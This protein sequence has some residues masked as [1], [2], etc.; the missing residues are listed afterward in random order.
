MVRCWNR[1]VDGLV[2]HVIVPVSLV[3][4]RQTYGAP[5]LLPEG[6]RNVVEVGFGKLAG[7]QWS[8]VEVSEKFLGA[9]QVTGAGPVPVD[10]AVR[11]VGQ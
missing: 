6:V 8:D 9:N 11:D 3:R 1:V 5:V 4:F 10:V 2:Q 7:L